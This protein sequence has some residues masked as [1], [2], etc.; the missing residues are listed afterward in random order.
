MSER[1]GHAVGVRGNNPELL[2]LVTNDRHNLSMVL[3]LDGVTKEIV[4]NDRPSPR[5]RRGS[6]KR[7]KSWLLR[8]GTIKIAAAILNALSL[9]VRFFDL[10]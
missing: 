10:F 2:L 6:A 4:M 1:H 8:P 3:W 5:K 9:V 7:K